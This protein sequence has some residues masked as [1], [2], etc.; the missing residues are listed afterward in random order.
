M[1]KD[2]LLGENEKVFDFV[3]STMPHAPL[4]KSNY[5][6]I[7]VLDEKDQLTGGVIFHSIDRCVY[8][9][10]GGIGNWLKR[11]MVKYF[12]SV[13]FYGVG[14][15]KIEVL[16]QKNDLPTRSLC[17]SLGFKKEGIIRRF[18]HLNDAVLY[19]MFFK[20]CLVKGVL[21]EES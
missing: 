5:T 12:F 16:V 17:K 4:S 6:A 2:Y 19:G 21:W 10:A 9:A 14:A 13:A 11:S 1:K 8:M 18:F 3:Q 15:D 20:E 7:G